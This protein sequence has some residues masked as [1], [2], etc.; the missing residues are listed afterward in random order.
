MCLYPSPGD[1][2]LLKALKE[3]EEEEE[4][5]RRG[6]LASRGTPG[7]DSFSSE[8]QGK[9]R[10]VQMGQF[11][12]FMHDQNTGSSFCRLSSSSLVLPTNFQMNPIPRA[13]KTIFIQDNK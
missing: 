3:E 7:D 6:G 9:G 13:I 11:L 1:N 12:P 10:R 2:P 5:I 8:I 4:E